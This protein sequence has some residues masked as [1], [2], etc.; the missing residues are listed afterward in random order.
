M[1]FLEEYEDQVRDIEET[2]KWAVSSHDTRLTR[3]KA[4]F[5]P[6]DNFCMD[7]KYC[8]MFVHASGVLGFTPTERTYTRT[9]DCC[10]NTI[11]I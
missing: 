5:E 3:V 2:I 6:K 4:P 7:F 1:D 11:K 10:G 8:T 9:C